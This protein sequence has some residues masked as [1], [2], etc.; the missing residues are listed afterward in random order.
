MPAH[1]LHDR[2]S[3]LLSFHR[4]H[5]RGYGGRRM[6]RL[7]STVL[8]LGLAACKFAPPPDVLDTD[9][10][11]GPVGGQVSGLWT[12]AS[13][14]LR[15]TAPGYPDQTLDVTQEGAFAF[16]TVFPNGTAFTLSIDSQPADHTCTVPTASGEVNGP[17][18]TAVVTCTS[19]IVVGVSFLTP[20]D[21]DFDPQ[22]S[23]Q[24]T[25]NLSVL[26]SDARLFIDGPAGSTGR[27][28]G[29]ALTYQTSATVELP[30][31]A[32]TVQVEFTVGSLSRRYT[33]PVDRGVND[34]VESVY[35]KA[36]SGDDGDRFGT[37]VAGW[38]DWLVVGAVYEASGNGNPF[39]NSHI[40]SGAA[41]VFHRNDAEW[42]QQAYLKGSS[43]AIQRHFG[44][45]VDISGD[46]LVVGSE[47]SG[48]WVFRRTGLTWTE[49]QRLVP[50][51][52]GAGANV[53][54]DGEL[55]AITAAGESESPT[56]RNGA[57]YIY[58]RMGGT[59]ALEATLRAP[60][61]GTDDFFG[62]SVSLWGERVAIGATSEDSS[63]TG[64]APTAATDD[65]AAGSGAVYVFRREPTGWV[66]EA[67]VKASNT[68]A[69]DRFGSS[70]SLGD[71]VLAVGAP[72]EMSG[73]GLPSDDSVIEAGAVYVYRRNGTAWV[74]E[75]YLKAPVPAERVQLGDSVSISGD[76]LAAGEAGVYALGHVQVFRRVA[77]SW[78]PSPV[79]GSN[80]EQ[81][82]GFGTAVDLFEE[83]LVVGAPGEAGAPGPNDNSGYDVGAAY[84][85]R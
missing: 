13:L 16:P 64:V 33:I 80:T 46:T 81:G 19:S 5:R 9:A 56:T 73:T 3:R 27:L 6:R 37:A 49:E 82:D 36:A 40:G 62:A 59:W 83:G 25:V 84:V 2:L 39:D 43:S 68:G 70:V 85:Y 24:S 79:V 17:T 11:G 8:L 41:Y 34:P 44:C 15:L 1:S 55:I 50:P 67:Y 38:Q 31:G 30:V 45:D 20:A 58:R 10:A 42:S 22:V 72:A 54:I 23:V 21:F 4:S 60:N 14:G 51:E 53:A 35:A 74:H 76:L 26:Q 61:R 18:S 47:I 63:A 77:G 65:S 48:A 71:D 32:S 57:V 28:N 7:G 12:G 52:P 66:F 69:G 78:Q 29:A 75:S